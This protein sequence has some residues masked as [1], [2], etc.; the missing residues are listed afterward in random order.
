MKQKNMILKIYLA[1]FIALSSCQKND[2]GKPV[3]SSVLKLTIQADATRQTIHGFGASDAWSCQFVG[4]NWPENK[5]VQM[6]D[7]LFSTQ[8]DDNGQP[9]GI[10]LNTWRFNIGGGSS[11]QG[12]AS[13]ISDEWRRA[14]SFMTCKG[15]YDWNKHMGQRWFLKAAKER[16]VEQFVGFVNSPPVS[17]TKNGKAFS[18]DKNHFNLPEEH[19]SLF[20]NYLADISLKLK[21]LD[22]IDFKYISPF[23]EPQWDWTNKSQEGTPAQNTEIATVIKLVNNAFEEKNV[24]SQIEIPESAQLNFM[25]ENGGKSGRGY[26]IYS[27]FDPASPE[28]LGNLS[29]VAPKVAAHSYYTTWPVNDMATTRRKVSDAIKGN[30]EPVEFWMSEYCVL[31]NNSEIEGSGRDLGMKTALYTSRVIFADLAIGNASSWQWWLAISPYDYKDGLV[32]ID[33]NK[34]DGNIYDS[35]TLWALGNYSRFIK[36]GMKRVLINRSDAKTDEQSLNSIMTCAF[37]SEDKK[38]ASVI[39]TNYLSAD[40]PV[41]LDL[42]GMSLSGKLKVY[43][44]DGKSDNNLAF[45]QE[46]EPG[47]SIT[48]PARS[49]VTLTNVK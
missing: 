26:Q 48:V 17:L 44:T 32:Y 28:Y 12:S 21:E 24:E 40:V 9:L 45:I 4:K 5:K 42:N 38:N 1:V 43:L 31:E 19:Y 47:E 37:V 2:E 7:W 6:A 29:H 27:F 36:K 33:Y 8:L 13:Q 23:N 41:Q 18:S 30:P 22:A 15:V 25:Y 35:K 11:E 14:Q 46:A 39:I 49:V 10:G 20:A 3:D 34:T 16:G